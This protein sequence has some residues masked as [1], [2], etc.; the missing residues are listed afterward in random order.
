MVAAA[1]GHF[2]IVQYILEHQV[3]VNNADKVMHVCV[4]QL[5]S[6]SS[7]NKE[8]SILLLLLLRVIP[9]FKTSPVYWLFS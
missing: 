6:N 9:R 1:S 8:V 5:A 2:E 7:G 3:P 4:W